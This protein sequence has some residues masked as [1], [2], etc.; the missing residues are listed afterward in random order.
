MDNSKLIADKARYEELVRSRIKIQGDNAHH[1]ETVAVHKGVT[2]INHS[3]ATTVDM[4]WFAL[5]DIPAPAILIIGGVDRAE[6]HEKLSQLI[7][8][9]I[10]AVICFGSTPWKY[11]SAY[12]EVPTLIIRA[13]DISEAVSYAAMLTGGKIKT[14]LFSPSC[15][16]YDAFDN[17]RNR[18]NLFRELVQQ[19]IKTIK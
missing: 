14:V 19:K 12:R 9:K 10:S 13:E 3:M 8:E 4:T 6:D 11:F 18:G 1:L 16:S 2:W 15:P 7:A 5:R 17:Y